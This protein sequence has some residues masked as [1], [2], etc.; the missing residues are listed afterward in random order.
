MNSQIRQKITDYKEDYRLDMFRYLQTGEQGLLQL[1]DKQEKFKA[2]IELLIEY[3]TVLD[4]SDVNERIGI[5]AKQHLT[6]Y[7]KKELR[8]RRWSLRMNALYLIEDFYMDDFVETL[9]ELYS[10]SNTKTFRQV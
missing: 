3:S 7:I 5:F 8:Q 10:N 1:D 2:L 6:T 4:D 9:H